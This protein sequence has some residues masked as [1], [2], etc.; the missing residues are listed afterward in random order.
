MSAKQ[1]DLYD[2]I[3]KARTTD[4]PVP[5]VPGSQTQPYAIVR[6]LWAKLCGMKRLCT[7]RGSGRSSSLPLEP[8]TDQIRNFSFTG[9]G[10][11]AGL[12]DEEV[13][14]I[15]AEEADRVLTA[16]EDIVILPRCQRT[17]AYLKPW[18]RHI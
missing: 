3:R 12:T 15:A 2:R 10:L 9:G 7:V 18:R 13:E 4:L 6:Q 11:E 8:T 14:A 1:R 16:Y 17:A 5:L